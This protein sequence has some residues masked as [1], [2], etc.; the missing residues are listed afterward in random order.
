MLPIKVIGTRSEKIVHA[1]L[2]EGSSVT[3]INA[4]VVYEVGAEISK[5]KVTLHGIG[6]SDAPIITNEKT[7]IKIRGQSRTFQISGALVIKDLALPK[8][9]LDKSL[10]DLCCKQTRVKINSYNVA[11]DLLIG[12]DNCNLI[13]NR[14]FRIVIK[15][16]LIASRC[17]LGWT[18]HGHEKRGSRIKQT[19]TLKEYSPEKNKN[20]DDELDN[21]VREYF[22]IDAIGINKLQKLNLNDEKALIQ[23]QSTSRYLDNAWEVGL[24]WKDDCLNLPNSRPVAFR[25]LQ[26]LEKRLDRDPRYADMYYREMNRFIDQGFAEKVDSENKGNRIWYLPHFRVQNANK[27]GKVRLVFDAAAKTAKTSLNDLLLSGPDLLKSLLGVLMRFREFSV[28]I[29]GTSKI[30]F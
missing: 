30:C 16:T 28:A 2:D 13:I 26:L 6:N 8:Q 17:L 7:D 20:R 23:L 12:Q 14:E 25:R 3:I 22:D 4:A 27:P 18:L 24:P 11:P 21:V 19:N 15:E 9:I 10:V 1:L 5:S 29:K